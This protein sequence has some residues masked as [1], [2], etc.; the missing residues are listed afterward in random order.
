MPTKNLL[1]I[2]LGA[3]SGRVMLGRF[4]D[5][6][7]DVE[8]V[9]RFA[10]EPVRLRETLCWDLPRLLLE[11]RR[12]IA[13]GSRAAGGDIAGIAVD[14]W[15]VDF[16]LLDPHGDLLGLP[17]HYRDA[18]TEGMVDD[19]LEQVP[20]A[21]IFRETGVQ[22]LAINTLFQ[23][24]ALR[25]R[26]PGSLER[27]AKILLVADLVGYFLCG[28][29]VAEETLASTTQL[30][31]PRQRNWSSVLLEALELDAGHFGELVPPGT[32]LGPLVTEI[33]E[34]CGLKSPPPVF[35]SASHDTAAAIAAIPAS[36]KSAW[37]YISSGTWSLCGLELDA[38]AIHDDVLT[39]D[40]TN[41]AGAGGRTTFLRNLTGLWVVEECRRVWRE[42][43][44]DRPYD[45]LV[46]LAR[47][48]GGD[49]II[50]PPAADFFA[51]VSMPEAIQGYCRKTAQE[52]PETTG[53]IVRCALRSLALAYRQTLAEATALCDA[54]LDVLHVVG[55]G[56]RNALLNQWTADAVGV[57][58]VAGPAEGTALGNILVQLWG[59]GELDSLD[60][61]RE[62]AR[63][64]VTTER[65]EP[66]TQSGDWDTLSK[67]YRDL[68]SRDLDRD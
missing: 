42:D 49:S 39:R 16:G 13:L 3:S 43:G 67:R 20:Q 12:G 57:P 68:E 35:A 50:T 25:R 32:P 58:V 5:G 38:P 11:I 51:P 9:H 19:F 4:H 24:H 54:R 15:G 37:G 34:S 56:S 27:A 63:A 22:T 60:D 65:F 10:N 18:R 46:E 61:V 29:S 6:R 53:E 31:N 55:G 1:A 45:A 52:V 66:T 8:E 21:T 40:F 17:V 33:S 7:V 26:R 62:V 41:E 64:S 2:D 59:A 28:R 14:S 36:P 23:L 47:D 30:W 44:D 48:A